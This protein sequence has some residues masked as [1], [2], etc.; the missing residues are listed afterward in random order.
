MAAQ[1]C[2]KDSFT[3]TKILWLCA[4]VDPR[5]VHVDRQL[6]LVAVSARGPGIL[7]DKMHVISG[8]H[9]VSEIK[10]HIA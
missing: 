5:I 9:L 10:E 1:P 8:S 2:M 6:F 7:H 4:H 3:N